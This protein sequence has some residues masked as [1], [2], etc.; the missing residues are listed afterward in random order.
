MSAI[1]QSAGV[2][3]GTA[4]PSASPSPLKIYFCASIRG[5]E[6]SKPFLNQL[7]IHLK[8]HHGR[9]LTEHIG[10]AS[11][12]VADQTNKGIYD[13]DVAWL[14]ESDVC[15]AECSSASL[16]VG[17]ELAYAE[18]MHKPV[19]VLYRWPRRD[20]K[21]ISG[22][23][24]G[25]S[26]AGMATRYYRDEHDAATIMDDWI[27]HWREG[28]RFPLVQTE[29]TR[30]LPGLKAPLLVAPMA[31]RSGAPLVI[32]SAQAGVLGLLG[33]GMGRDVP[34]L[35]DSLAQITSAVARETNPTNFVWGAG[36]IGFALQ[37]RPEVLDLVLAARPRAIFFS[38]GDCEKFAAKARAAGVQVILSQIQTV[39]DA[40]AAARYSD[41]LVL[42][43]SEAGGHGQSDATRQQLLDGVLAAKRGAGA[44][45]RPDL[46]IV[47]A[48][49][50][51]SNESIADA[52]SQEGV[53]GL[54]LGTRFLACTE[55]DGPAEAK[56]L[57]IAADGA[58]TTRSEVFDLLAAPGLWPT[59]FDGRAITHPLAHEWLT[60]GVNDLRSS[61]ATQSAESAKFQ[62]GGGGS[63]GR[64]STGHGL[65]VWAGTGVGAV[66]KEESA[67][68]V[69]RTVTEAMVEGERRRKDAQREAA[70][71]AATEENK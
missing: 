66:T 15:I 4:T 45:I 33:V 29:V 21:H 6:V 50:L 25:C 10:Y 31:G 16:G 71:K 12:E 58:E 37:E 5:E 60:R 54:S 43:G 28:I 32:A 52:M 57:A 61:P 67:F 39:A 59:P 13:R 26:Y 35:K 1:P 23:I 53:D 63:G 9:V 56:A 55:T 30:L 11:C 44:T 36:F 62:S 46:P 41:V 19:L 14:T 18:K 38:F 40:I 42:Q 8:A 34:W 17:Y 22:M 47:L 20:G 69:V 49:G 2:S 27:R 65:T 64:V 70:T 3:T 48:G 24:S 51:G 68:E 7:M